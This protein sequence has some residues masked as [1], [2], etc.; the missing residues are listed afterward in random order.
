MAFS[1]YRF[2]VSEILPTAGGKFDVGTGKAKINSVDFPHGGSFD[3]NGSDQSYRGGYRIKH[4]CILR[5]TSSSDLVTKYSTLRSYLGKKDKLYRKVDGSTDLQWVWGRLEE[6]E[7]TRDSDNINHL[8]LELT[9]YVYSPLFN[10]QLNGSWR[11]DTGIVLDAPDLVLDTG[12]IYQLTTTETTFTIN[13]GGNA[14]LHAFEFSISSGSSTPITGVRV[15]KANETDFTWSGNL[16]LGSQLVIDF[17]S[18]SI[19]NSGVDA[20]NGFLLSTA[21]HKIDSWATLDSGDNT[22]TISRIGGAADSSVSVSYYD[23]W[24]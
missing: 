1:I 10:G 20:Y 5:G 13:N 15:Q 7:S 24:V 14:K 6:I 19:K 2:G 17:G 16:A 4:S 8:N 3:E 23:G 9:F 18:L 21:N 11:L 12:L 22:F